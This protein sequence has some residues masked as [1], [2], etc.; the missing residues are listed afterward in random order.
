MLFKTL[1]LVI[2]FAIVASLGTGLYFLLKDPGRSP[3]TV[4][5]LTLRIGLSLLLFVLLL[6]AFRAGLIRPHGLP[7]VN[8][9]P[10][11]APN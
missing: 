9:N 4:K 6:L 2:L 11:H 7:A 5:A 3:R 1:V 8:P 10:A